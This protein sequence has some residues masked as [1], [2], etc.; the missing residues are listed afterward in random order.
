MYE[1]NNANISFAFCMRYFSSISHIPMYLNGKQRLWFIAH[2]AY[3]R[4]NKDQYCC[5]SLYSGMN[6]ETFICSGWFLHFYRYIICIYLSNR[7]QKYKE[8]KIATEISRRKYSHY[9]HVR[10]H[11]HSI[12]TYSVTNLY[13]HLSDDDVNDF[14]M[15]Y[16]RN[17]IKMGITSLQTH[18]VHK[19]YL[20]LE[21][22]LKLK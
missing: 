18:K 11:S 2:N 22:K 21:L 19:I 9:A 1:W 6:S 17:V 13:Y 3:T 16:M 7:I 5:C 14:D 10:H 4:S 12:I 20:V 15:V 8:E